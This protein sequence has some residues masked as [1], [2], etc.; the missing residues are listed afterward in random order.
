ME[1][2]DSTGRLVVSELTAGGYGPVPRTCSIH[3]KAAEQA[4]QLS[5]REV[6]SWCEWSRV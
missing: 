6:P 1:S 5:R 3:T 2:P 4:E